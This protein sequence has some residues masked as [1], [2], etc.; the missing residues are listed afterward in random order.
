MLSRSVKGRTGSVF[1]PLTPMRKLF[2]GRVCVL[3]CLMSDVNV[4][5]NMLSASWR[6]YQLCGLLASDVQILFEVSLEVPPAFL[7]KVIECLHGPEIRTRIR[8]ASRPN[9]AYLN[10]APYNPHLLPQSF[11]RVE[12]LTLV[13]VFPRAHKH[14]RLPIGAHGLPLFLGDIGYAFH[15][16]AQRNG[17]C[18]QL[19]RGLPCVVFTHGERQRVAPLLKR[20]NTGVIDRREL[21]RFTADLV[22]RGMR[23][24]TL[25]CRQ[26]LSGKYKTCLAHVFPR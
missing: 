16:R 22:Y 1:L 14:G 2:G 13:L 11:V 15:K 10:K 24:L 25:R 19:R 4:S 20:G 23:G 26:I 17:E 21:E 9:M 12:Q 6:T 5:P 8:C 7:G 3:G 18:L